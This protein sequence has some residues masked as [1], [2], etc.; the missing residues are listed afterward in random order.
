MCV[1][2]PHVG[3][4]VRKITEVASDHLFAWENMNNRLNQRLSS[5][6]ARVRH[7]AQSMARPL[8]VDVHG[9]TG[10]GSRDFL[11]HLVFMHVFDFRFDPRCDL[12]DKSKLA[13]ILSDIKFGKRVA[14]MITRPD[15]HRRSTTS[16]RIARALNARRKPLVIMSPYDSNKWTHP[17]LHSLMQLL[18]LFWFAVEAAVV[19]VVDWPL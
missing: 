5:R 14:A 18:L 11:G 10:G 7:N 1:D 4:P 15:S 12:H 3:E 6:D 17:S 13:A 2:V 8:L 16:C 9:G 19:T